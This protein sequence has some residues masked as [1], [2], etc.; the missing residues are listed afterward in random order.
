MCGNVLVDVVCAAFVGVLDMC[1]CILNEGLYCFRERRRGTFLESQFQ[2][3]NLL[4]KMETS[5]TE[6]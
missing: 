3:N 1:V 2:R 6:K 5:S 4:M